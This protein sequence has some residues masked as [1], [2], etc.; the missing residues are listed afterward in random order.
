MKSPLAIFLFA[1]LAAPAAAQ[2]TNEPT[3]V[4][5]PSTVADPSPGAEPAS[6]VSPFS[7]TGGITLVSQYRF[8]G[9]SLSDE[10]PALQGTIT[11]SHDSGAYAGLWSSTIDGFGERGGSNAEVDLYAGYATTVASGIKLDG[12]LLYYAYP[13]S[14]GGDFEFFEPYA[15][16]SGTL[17]PATAKAGVAYA[18]DQDALG[19]NSNLY[20]Y[21]DLSGGLP[22]SPFTLK[23]HLGF[24]KG[25]TRLSPGG[26]YY[27][28]L[29]GADYTRGNAT[30]GIAYVN[31]D[32]SRAGARRAGIARDIVD[33]ALVAS[34]GIAF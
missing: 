30:L 25:D 21:G 19:G 26:D 20:V 2:V 10:Q 8:R 12:G 18:W 32:L 3:D 29:V 17:G 27:D 1:A 13:G 5:D 33:G 7:V 22:G 23:A 34:L 4:A 28:W 31:T 11:L 9:I 24:S 16:V 14:R 15:S 6:G